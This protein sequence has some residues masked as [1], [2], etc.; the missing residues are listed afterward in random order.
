MFDVLQAILTQLRTIFDLII[1]FQVIQESVYQSAKTELQ[2]R[3]NFENTKLKN[4]AKVFLPYQNAKFNLFL[5]FQALFYEI[6]TL[7]KPTVGNIPTA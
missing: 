1:N 3:Q 4:T 6:P 7:Q 5:D 2:A